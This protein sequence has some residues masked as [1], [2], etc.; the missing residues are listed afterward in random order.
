M[1]ICLRKYHVQ[2]K[3]GGRSGKENTEE[4]F[5]KFS[6]GLRVELKEIIKD[7]RGQDK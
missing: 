1:I 5:G 6:D 7:H 4:G 2:G 3:V